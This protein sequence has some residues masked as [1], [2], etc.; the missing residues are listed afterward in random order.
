M[1]ACNAPLQNQLKMPVAA[2]ARAN[3]TQRNIP[4]IFLA[5]H[6]LFELLT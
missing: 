1:G 3:R 6:L 4:T 2:Q 5:S